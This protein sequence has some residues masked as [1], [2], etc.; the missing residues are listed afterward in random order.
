M[1]R[2]ILD[3]YLLREWLKILL[4]TALGFPL[5]TIALQLTDKLDEY[6]ARGIKPSD[7]ALGYFYSLPQ[8]IFQVLPATVLFATVFSVSAM[9]RHSE[10][11]AA[12]A[13]GRSFHRVVLP[14]LVASVITM[15]VGFALG[16]VAPIGSRRQAELLGDVQVRS[17]TTRYNF[18][19]RADHGW[20][21]AVRSLESAAREM[22]GVV[23]ERAGTGPAYPTLA[24]QSPRATFDTT[25]GRW[26]LLD[27]R[28]RVISGI[29]RTVTMHFDSMYQR[30][31]VETPAA[32]LA[33]PKRPEEMRY[34]ELGR[35]IDD[36]ERSGSKVPKLKV[37][38]QLKLS[39]P[40]TCLVIALFGAPLALTSPRGSGAVGVGLSLGT[41]VIFLT[42]IQLSQ[43]IGAGGALPP[44]VAAWLPNVIFLAAG[45][46]LMKRA[47]T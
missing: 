34:G 26:T 1:R 16:E 20:V 46:W 5:V 30:S 15:L 2:W 32:L 45:I 21:Y 42:M 36:L 47:R 11:T 6:L 9:N 31:L 18:V 4:L 41:T 23:L 12:K 13:S 39:I 35:Y 25:T 8:Q 29:G 10:L 43:A 38:R 22:R 27:G 14:V 28:L 24:V 44:V 3:R 19:Y 37:E 17:Q 40:F 7:I 33:E